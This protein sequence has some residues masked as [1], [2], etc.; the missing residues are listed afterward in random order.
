MSRKAAQTLQKAT[1]D[2]QKPGST[3][4]EAAARFR[5][6]QRKA[7]ATGKKAEVETKSAL[8][9]LEDRAKSA[10]AAVK[11][12][13]NA[14][15]SAVKGMAHEA[16]DAAVRKANEAKNAV[17]GKTHDIED[18]VARKADE[19]KGAVRKT[20]PTLRDRAVEAT[21]K[22]K[23]LASEAKSKVVEVAS[24]AKAKVEAATSNAPFNLSEGVEGV[25]REAEK[26]LGKGEAKLEDAAH[27]VGEAVDKVEKKIEE[28]PGPH[29]YLDAQRPRELRPETVTPQKPSY[30]GKTVYTGPALPV[31][32]EPPPGYYI[33]PPVVQK[34]KEGAEKAKPTLPLLAP[35]VK[36]FAASE[37]I[38]SQLASTIDSL[39]SS[40][41]AS[42]SGDST[43]ILSKAQ[44]DLSALSQRLAE[45]KKTEKE[46]LEKTV[47]EKTREFEALLKNKEQERAQGEEGLKQGWEK[48]KGKMVDE[49]R[50][51][52]ESELES[53]RQGIE[54][55]L[56]EEVVSQGIELQR[57]WLRSI[58]TQV[59][60]E[61]GGRLAKLDHLTTS[62]KQLERIT[63]DNSATLDDNVRLHKVWSA[64]RAVQAKAESG[65]VSFD[66]E[67]RLLKSLSSSNNEAAEKVVLATISQLEQS[68][69]PQTGVKSFAALSS[70]FT[71]SVA[72]RVHSAA[73]VPAPEEASVISHLASA[74]VSKLM[75]TPKAGL[76]DGQDVS[77][78][79]ARAEWCLGEKDLDGAAREINS[80]KGWPSKLAADWLREA[81]RRLEV[82][83]AL[84]IVGAEATLGSL[85]LV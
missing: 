10:A 40:L 80:L 22:A 4:E 71:N 66:E 7:E 15:A 77:S 72:P 17:E 32:H 8:K 43:K 23:A 46:K 37:P 85:L 76:V 31:G 26:A 82:Q 39:T 30:E 21:D 41:S 74:T 54:Q 78:V 36:D 64:L 20:E 58:K 50:S 2:D 70:W 59:E 12:R 65:D 29:G 45:V 42:N 51:S 67:L 52:L 49:W 83:Q 44:D 55:R 47:G 16:E 53:Q 11:D 5:E 79:L 1:S 81:R 25:V 60:T 9:D 34:V 73:L 6:I 69:I 19:A 35:K 57:R 84:E 28:T 61:R 75:F 13:A 62:L 14:A 18:A 56:R 24:D 68:G 33:A 27:R 63:L 38:V 48:E 3:K